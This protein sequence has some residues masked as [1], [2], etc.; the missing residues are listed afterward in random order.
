MTV[1]PAELPIL[2]S[3]SAVRARLLAGAGVQV[4]RIA[5]GV[6]EDAVKAAFTGLDADSLAL[7]LAEAK[8][9][10][11]SAT[12]PGRLV[13]G[14]DQLLVM[15]DRRFDKPRDKCEAAAHLAAFS[16]REHELVTAAL[17]LRDGLVLWKHTDR[18]R[19]AMR[20]LTPAAIDAYLAGAGEMVLDS[21]GAYQLEG[22][23][24]QL[25]ERVEGDFFTV[26]G[27]PLLPLLDF[28]RSE[29]V[30]AWAC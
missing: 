7:A 5:S 27:L 18:A 22:L 24:A 11:I 30:P 28:L 23:G 17:A 13:L 12:Y 15:G 29:G 1:Q 10:A 21:V 26:L 9:A 14:G 6:D 3:A 20:R 8:A 4:E 16:G 19:L 25:F 2:A